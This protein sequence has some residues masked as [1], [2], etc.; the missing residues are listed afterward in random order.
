MKK[1]RTAFLL[2]LLAVLILFA[3]IS[4]EPTH[5]YSGWMLTLCAA[6]LMFT[7]KQNSLFQ[8]VLFLTIISFVSLR[9]IVFR[10][11]YTLHFDNNI[12][13]VLALILFFAEVYS[14]IVYFIGIAVN[15]YPKDRQT[16]P[17]PKKIAEC[18]YLYSHI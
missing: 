17:L 18:R 13:L 7:R 2:L 15:L 8:R 4:A 1:I 14:A 16:P 9:Y 11:L 5:E 12:S 10:S 6:L 3:I